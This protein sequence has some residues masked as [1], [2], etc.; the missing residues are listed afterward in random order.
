MKKIK[1]IKIALIG[2]I[3]TI[4]LIAFFSPIVRFQL[5]K[6]T[7]KSAEKAD[8]VTYGNYDWKVLAVDEQ[9]VLLVCNEF[10]AIKKFDESGKKVTWEDSTIRKWLNAEFYDKSFNRY[11]KNCIV[12]S[13]IKN[14]AFQFG[15][16]VDL[17]NAE[18]V[19]LANTKDRLFLLS[20]EE[21][22]EY[23]NPTSERKTPMNVN[24]T[25]DVW[26]TRTTVVDESL[27]ITQP[28]EAVSTLNF[29]AE[30]RPA[31]WI[32]KSSF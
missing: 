31:I 30:I 8:I 7:I 14:Q 6:K 25:K 15:E 28:D 11:E 10:V 2:V 3:A 18:M 22:E 29:E 5:E 20:E 16:T 21:V 1:R 9:K 13:K 23:L 32:D 17:K 4:G 12:E 19:E 27:V 26:Y 24:E